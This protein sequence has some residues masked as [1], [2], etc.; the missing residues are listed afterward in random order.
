MQ[1]KCSSP[2]WTLA[3][4]RSS[5]SFCEVC[6]HAIEGM[7]CRCATTSPYFYSVS[8]LVTSSTTT[9]THSYVVLLSHLLLYPCL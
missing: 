6:V 9:P 8:L 4:Q 5:P 2:C 7:S 3:W 1:V